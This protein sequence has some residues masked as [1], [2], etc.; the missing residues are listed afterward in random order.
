MKR[1]DGPVIRLLREK[2]RRDLSGILMKNVERSL[3]E[4][5]PRC[6]NIVLILKVSWSRTQGHLSH[7]ERK[8]VLGPVCDQVQHKLV[9]T[10]SV[11]Q[12][13]MSM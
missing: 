4:S 7:D 13:N 5:E 12:E 2:F 10:V 8:T 11:H 3:R 1:K 6:H 9:L